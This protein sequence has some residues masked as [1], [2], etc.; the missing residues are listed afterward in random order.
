MSS[1]WDEKY[2]GDSY[3]YG[4]EPNRFFAKNLPYC[5]PGSYR[6]KILLPME[7]E[8]RNAVHAAQKGWHVDAY[9]SSGTARDKA[10]K[11]AGNAGV[12]ISYALQDVTTLVLPAAE[13]HAAALVYAHL[14]PP[15][16][17]ELHRKVMNAL[18]PGGLLIL[19][20][21]HVSQ[22]GK[23]SGGPRDPEKLYTVQMIRSDF[24]EMT[25]QLLE[26]VE[27]S[28]DEGTGHRG[29]ASV[30]RALARKELQN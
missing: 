25:F 27:I 12:T 20:A 3:L 8:G 1:F 9:D 18:L 17:Q 23:E 11:L 5:E 26:E 22:L 19:E 30:V 6:Q 16:R 28:L 4:L 13:Y 29:Q 10:G 21:F 2:K 24:P 14:D 7:G 15:D